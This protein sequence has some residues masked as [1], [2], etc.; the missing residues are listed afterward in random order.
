MRALKCSS[1]SLES[2]SYESL[3]TR[4]RSGDAMEV[5]LEW[6]RRIIRIG[7]LAFLSKLGFKTLLGV[8]AAFAALVALVVVL[9]LLLL[10]FMF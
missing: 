10:R 3:G 1:V 8:V 5:L 4:R 9:L 7:V 6:V 2:L